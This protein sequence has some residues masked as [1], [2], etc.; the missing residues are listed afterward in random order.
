MASKK[1]INRI[2]FSAHNNIFGSHPA[3]FCMDFFATMPQQV[4]RAVHML[5]AAHGTSIALRTGRT[6]IGQLADASIWSKQHFPKFLGAT[7]LMSGVAGW[8]FMGYLRRCDQE[9]LVYAE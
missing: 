5:S 3:L 2:T 6:S 8:N 7:M 4:I 9:T 1:D